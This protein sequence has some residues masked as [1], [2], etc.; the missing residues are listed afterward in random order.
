MENPK[1]INI[2]ECDYCDLK[3]I[4]ICFKCRKYFCENCFKIIHNL[5]KNIGHQKEL[6][7]PF[8]PEEIN[9]PIH[10]KYPLELFCIN[11]KGK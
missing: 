8:F 7:D 2:K 5:K 6:I 4:N 10:S 1:L 9:C 11:D 3:A